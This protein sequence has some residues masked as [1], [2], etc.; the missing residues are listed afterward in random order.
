ML[1]SVHDHT[2]MYSSNGTC[3]C[4]ADI[5]GMIRCSTDPDRVSVLTYSCMTY[6]DRETQSVV[7]AICPF[8]WYGNKNIPS[9]SSYDPLYHVVLVVVLAFI[10][11]PPTSISAKSIFLMLL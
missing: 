9:I 11:M 6:D 3:Q 2:W 1:K 5:R 8:G 4:G 7:T 10:M